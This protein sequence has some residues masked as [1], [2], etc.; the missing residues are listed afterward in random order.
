MNSHQYA[1]VVYYRT[2]S[3]PIAAIPAHNRDIKPIRGPD[4]VRLCHHL[5][6]G[7]RRGGKGE[8]QQKK[9]RQLLNP[10]IE[11]TDTRECLGH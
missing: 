8:E 2:T 11:R 5:R 3:S 1:R 4:K 10:R 6:H 9:G 7:V